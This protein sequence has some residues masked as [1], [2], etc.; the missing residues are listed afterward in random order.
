MIEFAE[1]CDIIKTY[2]KHGWTLRRVLLSEESSTGRELFGEIEPERSD[3]DA[4]WF[5]RVSKQGGT[6]WEIRHLS[7]S[8]LAYLTIVGDDDDDSRERIRETEQRMRDAI[9]RKNSS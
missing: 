2:E 7:S 5:S 6:A 4:V 3:I 1:I 8:P 9:G